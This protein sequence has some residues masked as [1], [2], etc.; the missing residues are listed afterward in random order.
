[1]RRLEALLVALVLLGSCSS[2][3]NGP[4]KAAE[5]KT[6]TTAPTT[7]AP[8][9]TR[10][11]EPMFDDVDITRD[12]TYGSAPGVD[13]ASETLKL[14]VYQPKDDTET[15]RAAVIFVHG[16]GF[17]GGNKDEVI[18]VA[19]ATALA[20]L[21]YV[22]ASID[23]RQLAP[24]GCTGASAGDGTCTAAVI[25][26]IH[27]GQAAARFL[28]ANADDYGIDPN[29]IGMG[30]A[31]AGAIV[32][33]GV[34]TWSET[35]GESG[36]PGVSSEISAWMS[37]SGGLPGGIFVSEGDAPGLLFSGTSDPIVPYQ[38]SVDT[39]LAMRKAN[40]PV[41]LVTYDGAGHVPWG[42]HRDDVETKTIA[43]FA[44]YLA[45]AR[46]AA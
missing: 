7:T 29:R 1:M 10:Y 39:E 20:K 43:F 19:L 11:V 5:A 14:D 45:A 23:Y 22:T 17:G 28:R 16:G 36:T 40:V 25:G 12:I 18:E 46:A 21:G 35:P 41:E 37:F 9:A 24:G 33:M 26:G 27:D 42:E 31:S 2:D 3:D 4:S 15:D 34:G 44:T 38:W 6:T 8:S 30:G 32:A 13:G